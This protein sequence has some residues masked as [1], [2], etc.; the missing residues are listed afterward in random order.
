MPAR[1]FICLL[2]VLISGARSAIAQN[3]DTEPKPA[4]GYALMTPGV[5]L[6]NAAAGTL[7][8]GVGAEGLIKGGLSAGADVSYLFYP[9]GGIR[10]GFGLFSPGMF[11]QFTPRRKT[12]PF[13]AGGY[14]L[15]FRGDAFNLIH[16]GGG[17]NHW[18]NSRWGIR[19]EVR[20]HIPAR[21]AADHLL[22]F[23]VAFLFR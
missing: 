11:Y 1:S 8:L 22:Q 12:V 4:Y 16:F 15:A 18:V 13:V 20:D 14:S 10:H 19:I 2:V 9:Q 5:T 21:S 17:V 6:G 7:A 23:R 3:G